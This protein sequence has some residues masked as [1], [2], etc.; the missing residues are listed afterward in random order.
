MFGGMEG[1]EDIDTLGC[2]GVAVEG[3]LGE[4]PA[5]VVGVKGE[6]EGA[7]F[8]VVAGEVYG[9]GVVGFCWSQVS[10]ASRPPSVKWGQEF[11]Q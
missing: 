3:V 6:G 11:C 2:E 9:G 7:R 4:G 8:E 10:R 1:I 5:G